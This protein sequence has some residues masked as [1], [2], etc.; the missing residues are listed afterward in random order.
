MLKIMNL[1]KKA[2]RR[3]LFKMG[4]EEIIFKPVFGN[5]QRY[6]DSNYYLSDQQAETFR[7]KICS[8]NIFSPFIDVVKEDKELINKIINKADRV[9]ENEYK[10]FDQTYKFN[11]TIKWNISENKETYPYKHFTKIPL[12]QKKYGDIKYNWELNKMTFLQDLA[13]AYFFTKDEKYSS[14]VLELIESWIDSNPPEFGV[15]WANDQE[16]SYRVISILFSLNIIEKSFSEVMINKIYWLLIESGNHINKEIKYTINN[17]PNN[18]IIGATTGLVIIGKVLNGF[19]D[20]SLLWYKKGLNIMKKA[21]DLLFN[22]DGSYKLYSTNYHLVSLNFILLFLLFIDHDDIDQKLKNKIEKMFQCLEKISL[23]NYTLPQIGAWDSARTLSIFQIKESSIYELI[24][25]FKIIT[26]F[27]GRFDSNYNVEKVYPLRL[28]N[29]IN[30]IK[31]GNSVLYFLTGEQP[32]YTQ[33]HADHLSFIWFYKNEEIIGD[34]G[35]Y[36]YNVDIKWNHAFRGGKF[37]NTV[38]VND[39]Y[40]TEPLLNFR[41]T[42]YANSSLKII[43]ENVVEAIIKNKDYTHVRKLFLRN[44]KQ[45]EII[46]NIST[47]K[48]NNKLNF[49]FNIPIFNEYTINNN[50]DQIKFINPKYYLIFDFGFKIGNIFINYGNE[51]ECLGWKS[52]RYGEKHPSF[53]LNVE[54]NQKNQVQN[55]TRISLIERGITD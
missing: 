9:M 28:A 54:T 27:K 35:N 38:Y 49:F 34:S 6:K 13:L 31:N 37:H 36:K 26:N 2:V 40:V 15:M 39:Q 33:R 46:D 47:N 25:S 48:H 3:V 12:T 18:H 41:F 53:H 10:I 4:Y 43:R 19:Y 20:D 14:K 55:H 45:L 1:F 17:V 50:K 22:D 21:I 24:L 42:K 52:S 11:N 7:K 8:P 5:Y 44:E 29:G 30:I 51:S 23:E 16:I 32:E